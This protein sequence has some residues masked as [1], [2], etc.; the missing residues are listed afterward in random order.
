MR[1]SEPRR[2]KMGRINPTVALVRAVQ[3][4]TPKKI[5]TCY[6]CWGTE[7][8]GAKDLRPSFTGTY[9]CVGCRKSMRDALKP[10]VTKP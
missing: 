9:T 2:I 3:E 8:D 10:K 6:W 1:K 7:A 5:P 4:M